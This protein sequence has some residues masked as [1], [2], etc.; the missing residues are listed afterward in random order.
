M[1]KFIIWMNANGR[2]DEPEETK[3]EY[4]IG[5]TITVN[6]T[7]MYKCINKKIVEGELH[8]TF[9]EGIKIWKFNY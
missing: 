7:Q 6:N 8:Q 5:E 2:I 4:D 9:K 3:F 1:E